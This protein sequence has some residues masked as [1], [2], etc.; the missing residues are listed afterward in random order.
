MSRE[1]VIDIECPL[2]ISGRRSTQGEGLR[3]HLPGVDRSMR[4]RE[5]QKELPQP[6]DGKLIWST[7][8][9]SDHNR[10][11]DMEDSRQEPEPQ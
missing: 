2:F 9:R 4:D 1:D 5:D 3:T 6:H 11:R 10:G 7:V 8:S